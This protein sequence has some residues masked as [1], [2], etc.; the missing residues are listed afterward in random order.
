MLK[1]KSQYHLL[2]L[3]SALALVV[4]GFVL[5]YEGLLEGPSRTTIGYRVLTLSFAT[6]SLAL[7]LWRRQT[8]GRNTR[9]VASAITL[10][11]VC[12]VLFA[13]FCIVSA[14]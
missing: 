8:F 13:S 9:L 12:A 2:Q 5:A 6:L 3:A 1:S 10:L 7:A 14:F 11:S 4:I